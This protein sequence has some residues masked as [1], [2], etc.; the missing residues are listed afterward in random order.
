YLSHFSPSFG[1]EY[2]L[3]SLDFGGWQWRLSG[4]Q[5]FGMVALWLL[6]LIH[7]S[8]VERGAR[9]QVL[10][11][12]GKVVVLTALVVLGF[13]LG[14]GD[15]GHF[16]TGP[17]GHLPPGAL[18]NLP[19]SLIF[20]LYCYSGWNAAAYLAGEV[21]DPHRN[22]PKSLLVGTVF[23]GIL[24]MGL[25]LLFIYSLPLSEM[26]GVLQIGEKASQALFGASATHLVATVMALSILASA[27][28]MILAGPRV[29]YAMASDGVIPRQLAAVHARY[30]SPAASILLQSL[31]TSVL[32]LSGTFEQLIIYSGF[33]LVL[34]SALA[35]AS[36]IVLR[37]R[38][39]ELRRPFRVP[40]YPFTP[41]LFVGF[42][43]WILYF[44]LLDK[45]KESLLGIATACISIPMFY[46]WRKRPHRP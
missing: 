34:F 4:A 16:A 29:Y 19:V 18:R 30:R 8:G 37:I 26:S 28:A 2:I 33:M 24:Y 12:I 17:E 45:P 15:W 3:A 5:L 21:R 39:P 42:S 10:I 43:V 27:S 23:V 1:P 38:K 40:L 9:F 41:L 32:L 11:T 31:W 6:T 20:V 13:L 44:T 22:I 35:V 36:V 46:Y 7:I 25:N 14:T